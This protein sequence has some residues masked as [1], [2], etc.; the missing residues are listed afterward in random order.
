MKAVIV[1]P[2]HHAWIIQGDIVTDKRRGD[3][4]AFQRLERCDFCLL[5][6]KRTYQVRPSWSAGK[7]SYHGKHIPLEERT[8]DEETVR[9]YVAKTSP[10]ADIRALAKGT[11]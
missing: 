8:S 11:R 6:R 9:E 3:V 5:E 4:W 2:R 1:H 7:L 10:S